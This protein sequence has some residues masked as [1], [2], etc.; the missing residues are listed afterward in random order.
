MDLTCRVT[1]SRVALISSGT[2]PPS[3]VVGGGTVSGEEDWL[4]SWILIFSL[5]P[6]TL[7]A[8]DDVFCGGASDVDPVGK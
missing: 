1:L 4:E 3:L 6:S 7:T 8:D 2:C 5:D